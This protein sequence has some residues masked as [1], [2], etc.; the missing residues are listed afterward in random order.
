VPTKRTPL[1]RAHSQS[2]QVV[3]PLF[4]HA[5]RARAKW[6]RS[7]SDADYAA[8][9]EAQKD[10]DRALF[11]PQRLWRTSIFDFD[12]IHNRKAPPE[13]MGPRQ[14]E[15]WQRSLELRLALEQLDRE[16]REA[17]REVPQPAEPERERDI[18]QP[19]PTAPYSQR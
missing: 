18:G 10:V 16:Q 1:S 4:Q 6:K 11:G 2:L 8:A 17:E 15:D 12:D 14:R 13:Y 9:I 7:G 19:S 5:L 3:L